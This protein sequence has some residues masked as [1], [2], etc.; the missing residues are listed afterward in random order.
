MVSMTGYGSHRSRSGTYSYSVE[1][2]SVN[3]RFLEIQIR[4]PQSLAPWEAQVRKAVEAVAKRG[5]IDVWIDLSMNQGTRVVTVNSALLKAYLKAHAEIAT[6]TG[7]SSSPS[8]ERLMSL[9][10][11][12][13]VERAETPDTAWKDLRLGLDL[14]LSEFTAVRKHDGQATKRDLQKQVTLLSK[15]VKNIKKRVKRLVPGYASELTKR[16]ETMVGHAIDPRLIL[17]EAA[18]IAGRTDV[19]EELQRLKSHLELFSNQ[20][21]LAT[22]CGKTL[23]FIAQEINRE[24]NTIGSKQTDTAVSAE[25]IA[26]KAILEKI[27]EQA[28][29]VE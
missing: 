20:M 15:A 14:A 22:P 16:L 19:N 13:A 11:V 21:D 26:M 28:R 3:N 4:I 27:R 6:L 18:I 7:D 10:G 23:D 2:K 12:L 25:V 29:N 24:I 17:S 1:V 9:D 8:V 5:K